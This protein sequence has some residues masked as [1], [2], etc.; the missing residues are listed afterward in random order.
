MRPVLT[1]AE[2]AAADRRAIATGT[3]E[4]VLVERA[5][6]AVAG[7][8]LA[9]LG[10]TYG[11][12][13]VVV[14]GKGNN[15]ADGRVAAR[16]LRARGTGVDELVLETGF[17]PPELRRV[18]ARA[19]LVIDAMYGTGFRGRLDGAAEMVVTELDATGVPVLAIDIPSGVDGTTGEVAGAAV[20]ANE[21]ICFAAYKP[22]LLF[23][24]GRTHA[25]RVRVVDIGIDISNDG[26]NAGPELAVLDVAD[27]S[28][29]SRDVDVHKWSSGCLVVGGSGGMIGAPMLASQAA[30]R[31][32]AGMVVCA[33]PGVAAAATVSARELVARALPATP[34]GALAEDAA[35][36]VLKEV[37]RYRAVVIGPGLGRD[38]SAQAA[39]RRIVAEA[40]VPMVIDA[41]A[42]NAVA[43][44]PAALRVRHAA[45]L[46]VAVLTPHAGEYERLAGHPVGTD[47]LESAREL[48]RQLHA[49]VLLK[50]SSTVIAAPGGRAVINITGTPVLATA[51][52]GDVLSGVIAAL[53][54]QG[55][56]PFAAAATG[57]YVH[58]RAARAAPMT[59]D[60]V[61]SDLVLA[62]PRTLQVLRTGRDPW[63][64]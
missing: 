62:L 8:A 17:E 60:I 6:R 5:G 10:G 59:P 25:G 18:L 23:E 64:M 7:Q 48:A 51:G 44:D 3:P 20:R 33:V 49:I 4:S 40:N 54:A 56:D 52:T 15:G 32:G 22:G 46:P 39:A 31:C 27:L 21:T 37:D 26:T 53:L 45:G 47:R 9:M 43:V 61:A 38:Q 12:R 28:L 1:P 14:C 42:L 35:D 30:L 13:V 29:P 19:D 55:V 16:L 50:G 36:A 24:P 41:D 11:R 57:A 2:M 34:L 63:E 58:G